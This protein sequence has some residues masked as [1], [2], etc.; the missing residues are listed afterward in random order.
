MRAVFLSVFG[1]PPELPPLMEEGA[2]GRAPSTRALRHKSF[3][4]P[5]RMGG[6][7]RTPQALP[8]ATDVAMKRSNAPLPQCDTK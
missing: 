5:P 1:L 4:V 7:K 2:G 6:T 3:L 8:I